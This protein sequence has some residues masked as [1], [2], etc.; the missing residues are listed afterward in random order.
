M[1]IIERLKK[2]DRNNIEIKYTFQVPDKSKVEYAVEMYLF[3][4][5][6][7]GIN[8]KTYSIGHFYY[9]ERNHIRLKTPSY[10]LQ[11][12]TTGDASPLTK[13]EQSMQKLASAPDSEEAFDEYLRH[14][15]IYCYVLKSALRDRYQT[16]TA[17][18]DEEDCQSLI[19][20]IGINTETA[21]Q[22]FRQSRSIIDIE[23]MNEKALAMFRLAD[24][25]NSLLT[26]KYLFRLLRFSEDKFPEA[27]D[28]LAVILD[29]ETEYREKQGFP[30]VKDS[31]ANEELLYRMGVLKKLMGQVLFI[32]TK[33]RIEGRFLEQIIPGIAAGIAMSVATLLL[34]YT[35]KN[36]SEFTT[37]L[38]FTVVAIYVFKDRIKDWS[39]KIFKSFSGRFLYDYKTILMTNSGKK[40]GWRREDF[41]FI[42][43]EDLPEDVAELRRKETTGGLASRRSKEEILHARRR[44]MLDSKNCRELLEDFQVD[45]IHDIIRY[46]L[47]HFMVNM[48]NP[49]KLLYKLDDRKAKPVK[50]RRV[51]HINMILRFSSEDYNELRR[52]KIV[53]TRDKIERLEEIK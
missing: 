20:N 45:G 15:Q 50:G 35:R 16:A 47:R 29:K 22:K 1:R 12:I 53:A 38:F 18:C 6:S 5:E 28:H 17:A 21:L 7:L 46:N 34:F 51:Y 39:V 13:L 4:P 9:D 23:E 10:L 8:R 2:H 24:E 52:F 33:T 26:G 37:T 41:R 43:S 30:V 42:K 32:K 27:M 48:D 25:Y 31:H 3:A 19:K 44:I 11:D 36:I 40:I 14:I 49:D